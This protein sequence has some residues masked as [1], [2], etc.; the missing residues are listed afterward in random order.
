M[1]ALKVAC[2]PLDWREKDNRRAH[3]GR[4]GRQWK[5][6]EGVVLPVLPRGLFARIS[7][8]PQV[9]LLHRQV[10]EVVTEHGR[11]RFKPWTFPLLH[12]EHDVNTERSQLSTD[13]ARHSKQQHRMWPTHKD[14]GGVKKITFLRIAGSWPSSNCRS[15]FQAAKVRFNTLCFLVLQ[16]DLRTRA[17]ENYFTSS[18]HLRVQI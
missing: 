3:T 18:F 9:Q 11:T 17:V 4:V 8:C 1:Y 10:S 16:N 7:P 2:M 12:Q 6:L 13:S 15:V 14:R 5:H